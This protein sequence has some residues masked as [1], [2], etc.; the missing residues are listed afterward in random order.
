MKAFWKTAIHTLIL[1]G[2]LIVTNT[3]FILFNMD[4]DRSWIIFIVIML[5]SKELLKASFFKE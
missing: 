3:I 1:L 5:W 4:N 2:I